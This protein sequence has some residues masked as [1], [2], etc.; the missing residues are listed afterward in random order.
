MKKVTAGL[1]VLMLALVVCMGL[2]IAGEKD[3]DG[4]FISYDNGTVRDTRTG[5]MWA[6]R[7]NGSR[8]NWADAVEYCKKY[9]GGGYKDWRMPTQDELAMLY[10]A[11]LTDSE[12]YHKTYLIKLTFSSLWASETR[13]SDAARFD[14][15]MARRDWSSK[16]SGYETDNRVLP[17]RSGK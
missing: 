13:G 1:F 10:D 3:R 2:A 15:E 16:Q 7:D 6:E 11:T 8:I 5:R 9:R 12:G 14:L 17:V 4:R